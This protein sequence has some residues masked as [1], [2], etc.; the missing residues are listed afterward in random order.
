META[1]DPPQ[2]VDPGAG[3]VPGHA[4]RNGKCV[5]FFESDTV[6][7]QHWSWRA[8]KELADT[9]WLVRKYVITVLPSVA[10]LKTLR[11]GKS[12][13]AAMKPM[14]GFGDP[15]F[16]KATQPATKLQALALNRSL[17]TFYRGTTTCPSWATERRCSG[18][19]T[20]QAL[21][22]ASLCVRRRRR[23]VAGA[24]DL[25]AGIGRVDAGQRRSGLQTASQAEGAQNH[26]ANM[27]IF[28]RWNPRAA[29]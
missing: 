21:R 16:D 28:P 25:L 11:S 29:A 20:P 23:P 22:D 13:L 8:G 10:S 6:V 26:A 3:P 7:L 2:I 5:S 19:P 9:D 27:R 17:T 24:R 12:T 18:R 4:A 15:I 14:I 1:D